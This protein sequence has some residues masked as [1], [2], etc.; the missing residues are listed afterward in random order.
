MYDRPRTLASVFVSSAAISRRQVGPQ[1]LFC[2]CRGESTPPVPVSGNE[3]YPPGVPAVR[4]ATLSPP[5]LAERLEY[6]DG[7]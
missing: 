7:S 4:L 2:T 3:I 1:R 6:G 5:G